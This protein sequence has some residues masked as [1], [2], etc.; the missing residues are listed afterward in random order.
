MCVA[1]II[2][3]KVAPSLKQ[4]QAMEAANSDGAGLAWV[5]DGRVCYTK[6]H[7][8]KEIHEMV[9]ELPRPI[10]VHFRYA[11]AGG[12]MAQLCHPFPLTQQVETSV[13][14][15][16]GAV[17]MH[18]GHWSGWEG[19]KSVVADDNQPMPDGPWSDTRLAAYCMTQYPKQLDALAS[20]VGGKL[21]I[22]NKKGK[23][24]TWGSW[25]EIRSLPGVKF[26]NT[27]WEHYE[28]LTARREELS[29]RADNWRNIR[30]S[31]EE[32]RYKYIGDYA[33]ED[34]TQPTYPAT[35]RY[36]SY[37]GYLR[38]K[39]EERMAREER[40]WWRTWCLENDVD[41]SEIS[42]LREHD[43]EV[44][45]CRIADADTYLNEDVRLS[46]A[47]LAGDPTTIHRGRR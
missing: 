10:F 28:S 41:P 24:R 8:A 19:Y 47:A 1:L 37:T 40:E 43:T 25:T 33:R 29:Q 3:G 36:T 2:R 20:I 21:A 27:Y 15:H 22:L 13:V 6:G 7:T 44:D 38:D 30:W 31:D 14:G 45:L 42:A 35:H 18:N 34:D 5:E 12:K 26:S 11:T 46:Q 17:M 9:V 16:A 23:I 4:F 39:E 32:G